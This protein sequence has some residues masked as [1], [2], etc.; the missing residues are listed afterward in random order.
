MVSPSR[1]TSSDGPFNLAP[2]GRRTSGAEG[3]ARRPAARGTRGAGSP[4][5]RGWPGAACTTGRR[6]AACSTSWS[7]SIRHSPSSAT[8][9]ASR[10]RWNIDSPANSPPIATPYSPPA[11][12]PSRH[13]ST[14]CTQPSWCR[15]RYAARISGSIQPLSRRGSAQA[16]STSSNAVSTR[17][18]KSRAER[19][20]DRDTCIPRTG[21]TP[22]RTGLHQYIGSPR[23]P[24]GIGNMPRRY[25]ASSV[26]GA[27]S[28]PAATRSSESSSRSGPGNDQEVGGGS[29][30]MRRP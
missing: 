3:A 18:S 20:S 19:R 29:T 2:P 6:S 4:P 23:V 14:E 1:R 30:G 16:S 21:S 11:R 24:D 26:P 7:S 28:A 27:R 5:R 15:R 12:R 17:I 10:S 25:A 22:R 9:E 8:F 13:A